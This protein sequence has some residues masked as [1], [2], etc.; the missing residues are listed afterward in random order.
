[1]VQ[2]LTKTRARQKLSKEACAEVGARRREASA[3]F[4]SDIDNAWKQLDHVTENIAADNNKSVR[5]VQHELHM[6]HALRQTKR[7]KIN[8]WNAFCWKKSK[9]K[10]DNFSASGPGVLP[11]LVQDL[12]VGYATLTP[13]E[14]NTIVEEYK[15]QK[16]LKTYGH[17][18]STKSRVNDVTLTVKSV[19]SQ[20]NSLH[21]RTGVETI[22]FATRGS[23]DLPLRT[24]SFTTPG[25]KDFMDTAMGI[26]TNDFVTRLEGYAVQGIKGAAKNHQQ[27][28]S[29]VRGDLRKEILDQLR[30]TSGDPTAK[31]QWKYYLQ[32]VVQEYM[33]Q[34]VGWPNDIPFAN[35]SD[36]SSALPDLQSLLRKW[37]SGVIRWEKV[38]DEE[39]KR[40]MEEHDAKIE[41]GEIE[42]PR[43]RTR[44]DKGKRRQKR[45]H[46]TS[47]AKR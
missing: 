46:K 3:K 20:L 31:M 2:G 37:K 1:R 25:V 30:A 16:D 21:S 26:E 27:R 44:S 14:K 12:R 41:N 8:S 38:S 36:I 15:Q 35:L 33:V 42:D 19:E 24:I 43:R 23:T 7:T 10:N 6:G 34:I 17:R 39:L 40:L 47:S 5:R 32:N 18:I 4:K 22:L 9:E 45:A 28:V 13:E 29:A 11:A